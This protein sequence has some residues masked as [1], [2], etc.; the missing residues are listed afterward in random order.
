MGVVLYDSMT[1]FSFVMGVLWFNIF[2]ILGLIMRKLLFPSKYS[3]MPLFIMLALSIIRML[4]PFELPGSVAIISD[5]IYPRIINAARFELANMLGF[6]VN[7]LHAIIFLWVAVACGLIIWLL[8]KI[9]R[10]VDDINDLALL[11]HDDHAKSIL[12]D[13][14]GPNQMNVARSIFAKIAFVTYVKPYIILPNLDFTDDEVRVLL[15]HEWKHYIDKDCI[16]ILFLEVFARIFWWNPLVYVLKRNVSFAIELKCDYYAIENEDDH[17]HFVTA[18]KRMRDAQYREPVFLPAISPILNSK[19]QFRDRLKTLS[20]H[21]EKA[22]SNRRL[23][24]I[25]LSTIIFVVFALSYTILIKPAFWESPDVPE[26]AEIFTGEDIYRADEIYIVDDGDGTFSL[27]VGG[28]FVGSV[29]DYCDTLL[30]FPIR[31]RGD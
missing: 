22:Y 12:T 9:K 15:K 1:V 13:M 26:S 4:F 3:T 24:N 17:L 2:I 16:P 27:Y 18:C 28:Q 23:F 20:V 31:N 5:N 8:M 6:S 7:V 19:S 14:V 30:F 21:S 25:C 11:P 29:A 10:N